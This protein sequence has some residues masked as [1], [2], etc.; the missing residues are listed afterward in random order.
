MVALWYDHHLGPHCEI[1]RT[2]MGAVQLQGTELLAPKSSIV[3]CLSPSEH[4]GQYVAYW[5]C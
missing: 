2:H 1:N 4:L 5:A 3:V